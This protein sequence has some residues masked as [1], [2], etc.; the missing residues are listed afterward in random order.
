MQQKFEI[1]LKMLNIRLAEAGYFYVCNDPER[2]MG[3]EDLIESML[4]LSIDDSNLISGIRDAGGKIFSLEEELGELNVLYRNSAKLLQEKSVRNLI[5]KKKKRYLQ[6]F[7]ISPRFEK[8]AESI[9]APVLNTP[10]YQNKMFEEKISQYEILSD[11]QINFPETM[12]SRLEDVRYNKL[13]KKFGKKFVVQFNRGHTG[14]GTKFVSSKEELSELQNIFPDRFVRIS[15]YVQGNTYTVNACIYRGRVYI[16]GMSYQITGVKDL[17]N[18]EGG[19]VG[20]DFSYRGGLGPN[21]CLQI[22]RQVERIGEV[23]RDNGFRGMYGVDFILDERSNP[24]IIEVNARQ[25]A[26]IPFY[27]KLQLQQSQIPLSMLHLME[28]LE[29]AEEIDPDE[30]SLQAMQPIAAA[31]VFFR[32]TSDKPFIVGKN[33]KTGRYSLDSQKGDLELINMEEMRL[34]YIDYAYNINQINNNEL[35]LL[36]QKQGKRINPGN[37]VFRVQLRQNAVAK[38]GKLNAW[39]TNLFFSLKDSNHIETE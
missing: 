2:A 27:T 22:K 28:F 32:N 23:M 31:Q 30:Y 19:T 10:T 14:K 15:K 12:I 38:E 7:K 18:S 16:G 37:E 29:V 17:T 11:K 39:I 6:T 8:I 26:S 4:I 33:Y 9:Q 5:S 1:A 21:S 20:N 35:L 34:K 36:T 24:F 25:P 3:L 13:K